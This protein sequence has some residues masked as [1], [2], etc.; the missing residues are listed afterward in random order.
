MAQEPS[1][2]EEFALIA[3]FFAPL[4]AGRPETCGLLDD[5]A[6]LRPIPGQDLVLTTDALVAGVHFLPDDPPDLI[7]RKLLGVNLS[8]LAAKGAHPI[9]Y[10]LTLA[11]AKPDRGWI[12]RFAEGLRVAQETYGIVLFGGDTVATPGPMLV[13]ATAFGSVPADRMIRRSGAGLG[14]HIY[15]SGAL[16]DS[17]LGLEVLRNVLRPVSPEDETYLIERYRVPRPRCALGQHLVGLATACADISD[18]LVADL[19]HICR[20]SNVGARIGADRLP[21]SEPAERLLGNDPSLIQAALGGGDDYELLFTAAAQDEGVVTALA[22]ELGLRLTRI[23]EI[24]PA[25]NGVAVLDAN[26]LPVPLTRRG[27]AHF[28]DG[29]G[30]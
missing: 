20:A 27:Y 10:L 2:P 19:G 5:A 16:G 14:D 8:D 1:P 12:A 3:E 28:E 29:A 11:L 7:A 13:S 21:L 25:E 6:W 4:T 24:V 23:G 30:D 26:G 17:A 18:G 15:V 22:A 9:G